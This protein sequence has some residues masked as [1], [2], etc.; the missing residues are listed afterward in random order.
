MSLKM[1]NEASHPVI[2]YQVGG[3]DQTGNIMSGHE[4]ITRTTKKPVYGKDFSKNH[5]MTYFP[6]NRCS[7]FEIRIPRHDRPFDN[8]GGGRQIRQ[9]GQQRRLVGSFDDVAVRFLPVFCS[10]DRR[11]SGKS[12]EPAD[13]SFGGCRQRHSN[14]T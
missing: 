11:P 14:P 7:S 12:A 6:T 13:F 1:L 5:F 9:I 2:T 3:S 8:D 4:L 10:N